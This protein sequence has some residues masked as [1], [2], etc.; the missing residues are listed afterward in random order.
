MTQL[1]GGEPHRARASH[2]RWGLRVKTL[3]DCA[4]C[5]R[6]SVVK[7]KKKKKNQLS[8]YL[9]RNEHISRGF[10]N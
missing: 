5:N 10:R 3:V 2:F 8:I 4:D 7:V 9:L 6:E 1:K